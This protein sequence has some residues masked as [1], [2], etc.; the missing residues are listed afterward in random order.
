MRGV[1]AGVFS[2]GPVRRALGRRVLHRLHEG[3]FSLVA[4]D[5]LSVGKTE[6]PTAVFAFFGDITPRRGQQ[7]DGLWLQVRMRITYSRLSQISLEMID[8]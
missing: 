2:S 3:N 7:L 8:L 5:A 6:Q 4:K 1:A